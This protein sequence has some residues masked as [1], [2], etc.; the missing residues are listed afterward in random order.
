MPA[1]FEPIPPTSEAE[2]DAIVGRLQAKAPEWA[3]LPPAERAALLRSCLDTTLA[4]TEEAAAAATDAKVGRLLGMYAWQLLC[5]LAG[6]MILCCR[7]VFLC[8]SA[9]ARPGCLAAPVLVA[10]KCPPHGRGLQGSYGQGIG[11]E[12][13][14]W[15][16][17]T[18]VGEFWKG[19]T[20]GQSLGAAGGRR[21][22]LNGAASRVSCT[23]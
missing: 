1:G 18:S 5:H 20:R 13:V 21:A 7:G 16:S 6:F 12:L 3:A 8:E 23:I 9:G 14:V 10:P 22:L 17:S 19:R 15:V 4:V 11:E 2:L